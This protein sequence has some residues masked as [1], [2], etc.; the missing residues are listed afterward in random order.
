MPHLSCVTVTYGPTPS[1]W[2][3]LESLARTTDRASTEI[4]VVTQPDE[5]G[6]MAADVAQHA[7]HVRLIAL[8]RNEGFGVANNIGVQAAGADLV[9]LL[10]PDLE[11]TEGWLAPL[12][13]ALGDSGVTIAA[14]P[15]LSPLGEVE[16]A[17]QVVYVDGGTDPIGGPRWPG[18]YD[19]VMFSRDVDYSSAACWLMRR[20]D[21]TRLAGFSPDYAPAY[22]EDVDLALRVWQSGGRCRLVVGRSVIH[23]HAP[24]SASRTALALRSRE[25]FEA[26]WRSVLENQPARPGPGDD[27]V[28]VRDHRCGRSHVVRIEAGTTDAEAERLVDE[29]GERAQ[30]HPTDRVTVITNPRGVVEKWRRRWCGVGLEVLVTDQPTSVRRDRPGSV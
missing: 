28:A 1:L 7:P 6:S 5:S 11:L 22:F 19:E 27:G 21:F 16:E 29:A 25:V 17:G 4:I 2:P 20:A 10:N 13:R 30:A 26:K 9:A 8:D 18:S 23:H 14:P 15:L 3:M 24:P 12:E